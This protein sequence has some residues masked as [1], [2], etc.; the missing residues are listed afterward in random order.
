[1]ANNIVPIV[2]T[3]KPYY[4]D[5]DP[6]KNFHRVL[7]RPGYAVQ[8]RELT[9][10]QTIMQNQI[11]DFGDHVFKDGSL[12]TG[13]QISYYTTATLNLQSTYANTD[14]DI[15]DYANTQIINVNSATSI[16][17]AQVVDVAAETSTEPA[18]LMLRYLT[19]NEFSANDTIRVSG[20]GVFANAATSNAKGTAS[21]VSIQDG[22]FYVNGFFVT[23][24]AQTITLEKYSITPSYRVGFEIADEIVTED[25]DTSLLDP[26]QEA[27]NYQAPGATRY[28][29]NLNL[30]KRS[31]SS[32]DDS[33]FIEL[34]RV[35]D[36][37]VT[38]RTIYPTY[39]EIENTLARRTYDQSGSFTVRPFVLHLKNNAN[40]SNSI[41]ATLDP[42][43]A[44]VLG[45]E[46]ETIAPTNLTIKRARDYANISNYDL[47]I[48]YGN[49]LLVGNANT[50]SGVSTG[51]FNLSSMQ[52]V[53]LHCVSYSNIQTGNTTLYNA[54]KIGTARVRN[55]TYDSSAN[56]NLGDAH[57]FRY[58]IFNTD[59]SSVT[60]T[61]NTA[62]AS[63]VQIAN[64]G[65]GSPDFINFA[66][67]DNAYVSATFTVTSGSA[68]GYT[69]S[70]T[71]YN[72][73]TRTVTLSPTF[74]P[75]YST[76]S[77]G[78]S[79]KIGFDVHQVDSVITGSN[80]LSGKA[81]IV[82]T[83]KVGLVG[84]GDTIL[85]ENDNNLLVFP[86]P[87]APIVPGSITNQ[88]YSYRKTFT[89]RT[90]TAGVGSITAGTGE[91]FSGSGNISNTN[92]LANYIV[93]V[94][95]DRGSGN[96]ANGEIL[97][98]T[99]SGRTVNVSSNTTTF[100]A[101]LPGDTFT[102][103]VVATV[104][105]DTGSETNQKTKT[106]VTANTTAVNTGSA[107]GTIGNTSV[108]L[109]TGQI[110]LLQPNK[111]PSGNDSLYISDI[112]RLAKVFDFGTNNITTAN[113]S[114]ATDITSRYTI[115]N[116]QRDNLYDHGAIILK[117]SVSPPSGNVLV[118][119]DYYNHDSGTSDGLGYFSV[120][121]YPSVG[122]NSGY[123]NVGVYFSTST[124][125]FYSLR[126]SI[127]FRPKRQNASSTYPNYT[128]EGIRIPA[129]NENFSSN[130]AYY[131]PRIDKIVLTKDR[132]FNILEGVSSQ[133]PYPPNDI[134]QGMTMYTLKI[135]AYTFSPS[136]VS[137][138]YHEHKRYTMRDIGALDK[139]ITNLEY[140]S[141]L[142]LL[143]A[144][145]QNQTILDGNGIDRVKYGT[146]VDSFRGHNIG[147]VRNLD[148]YCSIDYEKGELR[149]PY[150]PVNN[151]L[152]YGTGANVTK[153][154]DIV[155]VSY[156]ETPF[157]NQNVASFA[158]SVNDFLIARFLGRI[159]LNPES[160][161]WKDTNQNPDVV[162]N[163][164]G[165][166]DAWEAIGQV[167][168]GVTDS[169]N[170][171]GTRW[172]EW[173]TLWSGVTDIAV[174]NVTET[175]G[176]ITD[177]ISREV[178]TVTTQQQRTGVRTTLGVETIT[179]TVENLV[180][181]VGVIPF[182]RSKD[183][184]F[185]GQM[186]RP[187]RRMYFYF[188]E[189]NVTNYVQRSNELEITYNSSTPFAGQIGTS[190]TITSNNGI[191]TQAI[192]TWPH[193]EVYS[194]N[195]RTLYVSEAT[196]S[197]TFVVG[198]TVTGNT[199][200]A[201][202]TIVSYNHYSG[203]AN[204]TNPGSAN[205]I[206][207]QDGAS[208]TANLYA[209]N[210][211]YLV[212]GSGAG[213]NKTIISYN[214]TSKVV[215][216]GSNWTTTPSSNTRYSIGNINT[217]NDGVITGTYVIPNTSSTIF[218]T[219]ERIFRIIDD[220]SNILT[221]STTNGDARYQAQGLIATQE[222][223]SIS[224]RSPILQRTSLNDDRILTSVTT[225][226]TVI[227]RFDNTPQD[228][229]G[230]P[231]NDSGS[232]GPGGDDPLA[233]TFF[234]DKTLYPTGLFVSS[235]DLFFK[236]KDETLPVTVYIVPTVNGYP[237]TSKGLPFGEKT[238]YPSDVN[239]SETP[240][241]SNTST[242][243][244]FTFPAPVYLKPGEEYALMLKADTKD[245]EVWVAEMG[246]DMVNPLP[247]GVT[248]RRISEQPYV[249]SFFR[250][251]NMSTWTAF[252][253]QDLMFVLNKCVFDSSNVGYAY[254]NTTAEASNVAMDL[255]MIQTQELNFAGNT[256]LTYGY[257][258]TSYSTGAQE[259]TFTEVIPNR[260]ISF[261]DSVGRRVLS[262]TTGSAN[263][264]AT[265]E[266]TSADISPVIDL[267]RMG[268]VAVENEINDMGISNAS[269]VI[270]NGGAG[271]VSNSNI[272]VTITATN[273]TSANAHGY[274]NSTTGKL[275]SILMDADGSDYIDGAT[276]TITGGGATTNATAVVSSEL[277]ASGGN[278]VAR[279]ITRRISL[280]D[281]FD[282][283]DLRV[284]LDAY[285]PPSAEI[286]VYYKIEN[287]DD[288]T[289]FDSRPYYRME[290]ATLETSRSTTEE[291]FIEFEYRPSLTS[292]TISYVSG[293]TVFNSF[294]YATVKIIMASSSTTD[295]PRIRN[296][297]VHALPA[298]D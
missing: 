124:G 94:T 175:S 230:A 9:Q 213:E 48:T 127:D 202:A 77:A 60:G 134:D 31:L 99:N 75:Y 183:V 153:N 223:L 133:Y 118:C 83:G 229:G 62:T 198:G 164:N 132:E 22:V 45:Y 95:D 184:Y 176:W 28:K 155:T 50:I 181:D 167:L 275:V 89:S 25:N 69:G 92:K 143:E 150:T 65:V 130:F 259:S 103:D 242:T 145:A 68:N 88:N 196:G 18:T 24:P 272:S 90:F 23:T 168:E 149:P 96:L 16:V 59:F 104:N 39:S 35:V 93:I 7:Y 163:A 263:I 197:G 17:R 162:I 234:V 79:F 84:T 240:D 285:K 55:V 123:A 29:I 215:T 295:V 258:T 166:N 191:Q 64:T 109:A 276:V 135:P 204:T 185:I 8:A 139:R 38:K 288:P 193:K 186:F 200:G 214:A 279:Y 138:E 44:Y 170:P 4:D 122:T 188:D 171:F 20:Q 280:A 54:S 78:D 201:S 152:Q 195:T 137:V 182:I 107:N 151:K 105:I 100:N 119:V 252:Q 46:Y 247:A 85:F 203:K 5:F 228:S 43:K 120:D 282:A 287:K 267:S 30:S 225:R 33:K 257:K 237:Y 57:V 233:Q 192:L 117:S 86:Y 136:N 147:D 187:Q 157:V 81:N 277:N 102:A 270:T 51:L 243:T 3:Q 210:T 169:R 261:N 290:Q 246:Q 292:N 71:E 108:Y 116:G 37:V 238:L 178:S 209:G 47:A 56:T 265:L 179:R 173:Q 260:N 34:L 222:N 126:D 129:P 218:R 98:F 248:A 297:R 144:Q 121:S 281:G 146:L 227:Q 286:Y 36:G 236:A 32:T 91:T 161:L 205:T 296:L 80:T 106:L 26:A 189:T 87:Q 111:T 66:N 1:M 160:D 125:R 180:T 61:A 53:D 283:G 211:I 41:T 12:V 294:K 58:Y 244:T 224:V 40:L 231:N 262:T 253:N 251:Q 226:D 207:L 190:E 165:E 266:T 174:Q 73:V 131:I 27:S 2:T 82:N 221:N 220:P 264:R 255:M 254:F 269:I 245:Y 154:G 142:S 219:G 19:G 199:S 156:T 21:V 271:Y 115:D 206:T 239:I 159:S 298:A 140:Y 52:Q 208:A 101:N 97:S 172:N 249:G 141:S 291:D 74:S 114:S 250:S 268:I 10:S 11:A 194:G 110:R 67:T 235:V 293:S 212:A 217:L 72:A 128:I 13:G 14:I 289:S 273:G 274:I 112:Y 113:L 158:V 241:S 256:S 6:S 216:V 63:T 76:P 278:G 148:Y 49:Y 70:I 177:I 42:G 284:Y 15:S 232:A